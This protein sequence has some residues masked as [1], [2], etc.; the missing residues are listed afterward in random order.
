MIDDKLVEEADLGVNFFLDEDSL[1][2]PR[3]ERAAA[4]LGELNP[5][6]KG[7]YIIDVS[8]G[9]PSNSN[10]KQNN[11]CPEYRTSQTCFLQSLN[12]SSPPQRRSRT[13]YSSR[14][15]LHH[16]FCYSLRKSQPSLSTPSVLLQACVF[17]LLSIQSLKP[18]RILSQICGS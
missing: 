13:L 1:G 6:V 9:A 15:S 11:L 17:Q 14:H 12:S 7:N 5:D 3:A 18:T 8:T 16:Y 4:L 2:K 10:W